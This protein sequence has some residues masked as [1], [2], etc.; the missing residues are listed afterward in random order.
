MKTS[1]LGYNQAVCCELGVNF[2]ENG[3]LRYLQDFY[4]TGKMKTFEVEGKTFFWIKY[5]KFLEDMPNME[6]NKRTLTARMKKLVE[7]GILEFH[8]YRKAG[9]YSL[10]RFTDLYTDRLLTKDKSK[11]KAKTKAIDV[12]IEQSESSTFEAIETVEAI[13]TTDTVEPIVANDAVDN[14]PV[15]EKAPPPQKQ[16]SY[17]REVHSG[18]DETLVFYPH[19]NRSINSLPLTVAVYKFVRSQSSLHS[20]ITLDR[21]DTIIEQVKNI[22]KSEEEKVKLLNLAVANQWSDIS[23][24]QNPR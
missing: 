19:I 23:S 8:L 22:P 12:V 4:D 2:V 21:V 3:I 14:A 5:D 20:P 7:K 1:N 10:Y 18:R 24:Y 15:E 17:T 6:F 11:A 9:N 13:V 16:P